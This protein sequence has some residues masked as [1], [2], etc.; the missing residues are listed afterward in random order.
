M[1][2]EAG[3]F[4]EKE[5]HWAAFA[6]ICMV[7]GPFGWVLMAYPLLPT[8]TRGWWAILAIGAGSGLWFACA[9]WLILW[10]GRREG[11]RALCRLAAGLVVV[12]LGA[13]LFVVLLYG[14]GF[15]AGNYA[16]FGR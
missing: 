16:W 1:G 10:L 3:D 11:H 7:L 5:L 13:S 8:T 2:N 9:A 15:I 14:Q 4:G 12:S 6:A